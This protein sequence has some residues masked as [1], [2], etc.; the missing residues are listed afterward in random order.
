MADKMKIVMEQGVDGNEADVVGTRVTYEINGL[1]NAEA[2]AFSVEV[3][4]A[5]LGVVRQVV[6]AKANPT[7]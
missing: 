7:G 3:T 5:V 1:T 4:A 6:Q 2:N